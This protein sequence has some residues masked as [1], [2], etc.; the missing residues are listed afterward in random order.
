MGVIF[1]NLG[2]KLDSTTQGTVL[3]GPAEGAG[4]GSL[5]ELL[6]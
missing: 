2:L 4:L 6:F 1:D 3:A 5:W